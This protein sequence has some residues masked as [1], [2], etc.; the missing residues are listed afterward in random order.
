MS[1]SKEQSKRQ[2]RKEQLRR[3]EQRSRLLSIGLITVGALLI[4]FLIIYPSLKPIGDVVSAPEIVRENVDFNAVGDPNAPIKIEEYSDF[5]CPYCRVFFEN[6]EEALMQSYVSNGTVYFVY[7][8]FGA[9]IGVESGRAAEASYCAGDQG[10]FWEMHDIIF[11]NQTG[12]N[13]GAYTDRRLTAFAE[14]IGLNIGDFDSCFNSGKYKE[15]VEQDSKDGILANIRATPS[16]VMT[17]TVN[18][19]TVTKVI[20]GAQ[21][22]TAFQQEIEAALAEMG[23]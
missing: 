17:Y 2:A 12:E 19:E 23:Q 1:N 21:S 6:T 15:R 13:V 9:F 22:F 20:E 11:A 5:Q 8:S 7:K 16:F 14:N 18:G 3:K 4:A 10:R